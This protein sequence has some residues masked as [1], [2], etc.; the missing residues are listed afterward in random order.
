[1]TGIGSSADFFKFLLRVANGNKKIAETLISDYQ[2]F[3]RAEAKRCKKKYEQKYKIRCHLSLEDLFNE[4]VIGFLR[5]VNYTNDRNKFSD[6]VR[7]MI[8]KEIVAALIKEINCKV[9]NSQLRDEFKLY[10][11]IRS[12]L[13]KK[14]HR[15][16][17]V[18]ELVKATKFSNNKIEQLEKLYQIAMDYEND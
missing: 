18:A 6:H 1:M 10:R 9:F 14:L 8:K 2:S 7:K 15:S 12:R 17:T 16:P 11:N 5:A 13:F 4:G 3:I